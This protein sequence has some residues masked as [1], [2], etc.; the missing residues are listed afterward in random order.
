MS[1]VWRAIGV[2]GICLF[3]ACSS[4]VD[5]VGRPA[6]RG[7]PLPEVARLT[8]P[9]SFTISGIADLG[10][11][12]LLLLGGDWG[13][14][15]RVDSQGHVS[16]RTVRAPGAPVDGHLQ[17]GPHGRI[18]L[19]TSSP[20][21]WGVV[22]RDLTVA[23]FPRPAHPWGTTQGAP[24]TE[25][26]SSFV[27]SPFGD[28]RVTQASPSPWVA[29]PLAYV[30]DTSGALVDSIGA[31]KQREGR[32]LSGFA[33]RTLT[34][35][36]G[37]TVVLLNVYSGDL[38]AWMKPYSHPVWHARL[39]Q[40]IDTLT[41]REEVWQYPWIQKGAEFHN[42]MALSQVGAA[43]A[44]N[45]GTI[46][47]VRNYQATFLRVPQ[48]RLKTQG[49]WVT[50]S[51]ALELYTPRGKMLSRY[52]LPPGTNQWIAVG[53]GGRV[54]VRRSRELI[55]AETRASHTTCSA[56]PKVMAVAVADREPP[57]SEVIAASP[58]GVTGR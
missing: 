7:V 4:Q 57:A 25:L 19:W 50:V 35:A 54:F 13:T 58:V 6:P 8:M 39:P 22:S 44:G 9:D 11:C 45:D 38:T 31:I 51:S 42:V 21:T 46:Y 49:K 14:M 17:T 32:Y 18:L 30:L 55:I 3:L 52:D 48:R 27:V 2:A 47:A 20:A 23:L 33:A 56:W 10:R 29:A 1:A 5:F 12:E 16:P 28:V 53:N 34:A 26:P 36:V 41:P 37:D 40:S 15:A 24:V 43:A